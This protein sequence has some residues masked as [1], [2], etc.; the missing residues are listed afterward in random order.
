MV[1]TNV[2]WTCFDFELYKACPACIYTSTS[3]HSKDRLND[4][5]SYLEDFM[6]K[7]KNEGNVHQKHIFE[8]RLPDV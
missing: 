5:H 6:L 4:L 7:L 3:Q 8:G 1:P 2:T